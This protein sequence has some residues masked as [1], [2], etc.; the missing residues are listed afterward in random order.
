[1]PAC[2][3]A[4]TTG[5]LRSRPQ[6]GAGVAVGGARAVAGPPA[7]PAA[8][9][10]R[11]LPRRHGRPSL[12]TVGVRGR[13]AAGRTP[14]CRSACSAAW[15]VGLVRVAVALAGL[16]RGARLRPGCRRWWRGCMGLPAAVGGGDGHRRADQGTPRHRLRPAAAV[17]PVATGGWT[18]S[19][20][21]CCPASG[22]RTT[23]TWP[24]GSPRP[25]APSTAGSAP[26]ATAQ[27]VQLWLLVRDPLAAD[28]AAVRARPRRAAGRRASRSRSP[29]TAPSW[30]L[31]CVGNHVL[32][33]GATGAGK[34]AVL[35]AIISGLAP[36]IR[37]GLVK[38]WAID[39]KGGMELAARPAAVRPV[40]LRRRRPPPAA[41]RA[42]LA[43]AARGRRRRDAPPRRPADAAS[44]ASTPPPS[45]S[46]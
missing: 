36:L 27:R 6:V 22:C 35:W 24:T 8:A 29:R 45:A 15:S 21:G 42:A 10:D 11:P 17:G 19:R 43:A 37:A 41:T 2:R 46:R 3:R 20:C 18:R 23:S 30:R 5:R 34:S 38:V 7:G 39:P 25:S 40:R 12:L 32:I 31:S 44:P 9:A 16:V 1:M 33:V 28:R 26:A 4:G 13:L 14:P